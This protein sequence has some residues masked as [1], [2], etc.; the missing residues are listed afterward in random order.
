MI[1]AKPVNVA[2]DQNKSTD[3]GKNISFNKS[4]DSG[5]NINTNNQGNTINV[6]PNV[7]VI[8]TPST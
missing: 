7:K 5:N 2:V 8:V 3:S 4:T 1:P 6:K